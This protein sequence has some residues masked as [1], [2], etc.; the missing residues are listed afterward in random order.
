MVEK[1]EPATEP[2]E[3]ISEN[4][5]PGQGWAVAGIVAGALAFVLIPPLLGVLGIVFGLIG[6][7][8]GARRM[9]KIAVGVS[10]FSLVLGSVLYVLL[11]DL[12]AT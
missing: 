1:P 10:I 2:E 7:A 12:I 4:R 5:I 11:S 6:Y 9:G 8:R 3:K